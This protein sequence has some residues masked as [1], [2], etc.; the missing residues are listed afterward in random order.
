VSN[1][2]AQIKREVLEFEFEGVI[3]NGILNIPE[4][5]SLKEIV[6]IVHGSGQ[7]NAVAQEWYYDVRETIVKSGYTVYMWDKRGCGNSS[8]TFDY[9]QAVQNNASEV[10]AAINVLKKK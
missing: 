6:L 5:A 7:T 8:G 10:I 2:I 9:N 4:N 1:C 3:L